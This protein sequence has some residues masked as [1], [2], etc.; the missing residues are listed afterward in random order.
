MVCNKCA[1]APKI[2]L[3]SP[4]RGREFALMKSQRHLSFFMV[5]ALLVTVIAVTLPPAL[6][7]VAAPPAQEFSATL[8]PVAGLVQ[9]LARGSTEWVTLRDTQLFGKGDQLRTGSDGYARLNVVSGIQIDVYQTAILE[10][11][12]LAM[13]PDSGETF[14]LLQL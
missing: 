10:M 13:G 6:S 8:T 2:A 14:S 5:M 9:Y 11:N 7:A 1:E 3:R 12:S 4:N